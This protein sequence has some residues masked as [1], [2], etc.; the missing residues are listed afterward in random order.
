MFYGFGLPRPG[1][2]SKFETDLENQK[3]LEN[4]FFHG[5]GLPRPGSRSKFETDLENPENLEN[6]ENQFLFMVLGFPGPEAGASLKQTWKTWK[7]T[8]FFMVLGFPG[9]EAGAS[10][11]QTWKTWKTSLL[12]GFGLPR[13]GGR[14][15][16]ETDLENLENL[17]N[18]FF[19]WFGASQA[20]RPEQV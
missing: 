5:F 13:P 9:P 4:H 20:R 11:K 18:Q 19:S 6:L 10:L 16:F 15:K 2:R 1:S 12:H 7:T 17:E 3:N 14:N 8:V